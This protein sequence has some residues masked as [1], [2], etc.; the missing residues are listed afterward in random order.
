[1]GN[2]N[3]HNI[4]AI[5]ETGTPTLKNVS[6]NENLKWFAETGIIIEKGHIN[7]FSEDILKIKE[8]Y[9]KNGMFNGKKVVFHFRDIR[10]KVGPFNP[11]VINYEQF[12]YD[13]AELIV[14][15]PFQFSS[16]VINKV[17]HCRRY[18]TPFPVYELSTKFLF[19]RL[20]YRMRMLNENCVIMFESRGNREDQELLNYVIDLI[21]KGN[22][23]EL[24]FNN[25][26]G[27][28]FNKKRTENDTKSYW[29]LEIAD[30]VSYYVYE[31]KNSDRNLMLNKI[32]DKKI[33]K[34]IKIFPE[35]NYNG[36]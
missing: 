35:E 5:D 27:V 6:R 17:D 4:I 10:K 18:K 22:E 36:L 9:W 11:K 32:I 29:P 33:Y 34:G 20:T 30:I 3:I 31:S 16:A 1:M 14:S 26:L 23:Y 2:S 12:I 19:E 7:S 25:I 24:N 8:K 13:L 21:K 15:L 28:Y